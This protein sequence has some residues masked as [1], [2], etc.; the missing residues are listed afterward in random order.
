MKERGE[1]TQ[2]G[3]KR[4]LVPYGFI[5]MRKAWPVYKSTVVPPIGVNTVMFPT[6][7]HAQGFLFIDI[8]R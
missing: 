7:L 3:G 4:D 2:R 8:S 1:K 5:G 6:K